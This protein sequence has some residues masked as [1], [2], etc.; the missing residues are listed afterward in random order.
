MR[1]VGRDG[2]SRSTP[3]SFPG[4]PVSRYSYTPC[5]PSS[6]AASRSRR[7]IDIGSRS[8]RTSAA[9]ESAGCARENFHGHSYVCDVTVSG[10]IDATTGMLIDLA[11]LDR[12]LS[13]E[14]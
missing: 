10:E 2:R 3:R 6:H 9:R 13:T 1:G 7:P 11:V 12:I 14:V 5:L 4:W 8:G